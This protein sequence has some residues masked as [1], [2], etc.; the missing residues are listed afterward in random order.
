VYPVEH[1]FTYR[2][3]YLFADLDE[4]DALDQRVRWFSR[5]RFNLFSLYDSDHGPDD[6][7]SLRAWINPLLERAG[8]ELDAG[9]VM[10]LAYPRVLGY[11]FNP[12]AVWYCFGPDRELRALVYEVR[13]T[14]G[15][16]H[17]Y[18][19]PIDGSPSRHAVE[20]RMHV[21][22]FMDI[23]QTYRFAVTRPGERFSLGIEVQQDDQIIFRASMRGERLA[24]CN[25]NLIRLFLTHPL[26]TLKSIAAIHWEA[27]FIW[28][29][30]VGFRPRPEPATPNV[31]IVQPEEALQ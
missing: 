2:V 19:V 26:V 27:L 10:L 4:L 30:K 24:L 12:L 25:R 29:K 31:T 3:F 1:S 6:G 21:S 14:F 16:K 20:K 9:A 28:A 11:V 13:N 23:D 8:V 22:P 17:S 18:V 5:N 7:T 15:D